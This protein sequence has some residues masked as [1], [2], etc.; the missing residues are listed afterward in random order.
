MKL[1]AAGLSTAY[2]DQGR[3]DLATAWAEHAVKAEFRNP[4]YHVLLGDAY[5]RNAA[6][7]EARRQWETA[8][9]LGS[10]RA[11]DRL[12]KVSRP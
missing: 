6:T 11:R 4:E 10:D 3:F 1:A 9:K 5:Y 2:F 12:A 8:A 7:D